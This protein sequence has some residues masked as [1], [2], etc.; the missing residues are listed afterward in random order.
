MYR[1]LMKA[2]IVF[3]LFF[4]GTLAAMKYFGIDEFDH[5]SPAAIEE[6]NRKYKN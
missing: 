6:F 2:A 4:V 3:I 1:E 5:A